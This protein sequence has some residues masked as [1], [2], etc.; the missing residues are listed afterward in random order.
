M[1]FPKFFLH[2]IMTENKR[3]RHLAKMPRGILQTSTTLL[4]LG[5]LVLANVDSFMF[6][7]GTE[8]EQ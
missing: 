5:R 4:A 2:F 1:H 8:R 3:S 7:T 6:Y